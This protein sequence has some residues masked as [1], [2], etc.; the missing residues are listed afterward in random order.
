VPHLRVTLAHSLE[1][2]LQLLICDLS[3][4]RGVVLL[5]CRTS[6]QTGRYQ[7]RVTC[8]ILTELVLPGVRALVHVGT[9]VLLLDSLQD[10]I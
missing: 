7:H 3:D 6:V 5:S 9:Q 2:P 1:G 10:L 4:A 8:N